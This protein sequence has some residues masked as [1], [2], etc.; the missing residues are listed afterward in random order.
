MYLAKDER[1]LKTY[2][3]HYTPFLAN[4][5]KLFV[6][7]IPFYL[8]LYFMRDGFTF[9]VIMAVHL[10]IVFL[11]SLV[12]VYMTLVY[13][14]DR[15]VVTNRRIIFIDWEYLTV[16]TE[17][18][19]ELK[20]IQDITSREKGIVALIP[21]FD[22]GE[23]VIKTSASQTFIKFTEAPDPDGIKKFIYTQITHDYESSAS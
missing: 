15:L 23:L 11:F 1:I 3:H 9:G 20:D 14:L 10:I 18:E 21:F 6:A 12:A 5:L 4:L 17:H 19:S 7:T 8:L 16:K 13:W 22:Y 2:Y